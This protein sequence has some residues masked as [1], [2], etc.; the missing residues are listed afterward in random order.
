[1]DLAPEVVE[2][3]KKHTKKEVVSLTHKYEQVDEVETRMEKI[4]E[5]L[6]FYQ[7]AS[8]MVSGRL[9]AA[10]PANAL[11]VPTLLVVNEKTDYLISFHGGM[12]AYESENWSEAL[13]LFGKSYK[14][15][16]GENKITQINIL[17]MFLRT[18]LN[19]GAREEAKSIC[20]AG[21]IEYGELK[22]YQMICQEV[23]EE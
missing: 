1:M 5:R 13:E 22:E 19:L 8:L 16:A 7:G 18:L 3:I 21:E 6:K 17:T 14:N 4:E 2:V 11:G 10:L 15:V 12:K 23:F 20:K 9:H